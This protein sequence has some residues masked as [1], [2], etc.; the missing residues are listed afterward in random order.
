MSDK[1]R[2]VRRENNGK[3][4]PPPGVSN[5]PAGRP[6]GSKNRI[7]YDIRKMIYE[8]IDNDDFVDGLFN[9]IEMVESDYHRG[10]LK[11]DL[12]KMFVPRPMNDDE[13]EEKHVR[14]AIYAKLSQ[15]VAGS[16]SD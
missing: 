14:S 16:H 5:N 13:I 6:K 11:M 1:K 12:V 7:S 2:R 3:P 15:E 8:R 9:D 10:R 4:G